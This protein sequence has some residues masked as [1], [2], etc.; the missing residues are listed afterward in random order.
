MH[1]GV[2]NSEE[3]GCQ[4][5]PE[6]SGEGAVVGVGEIC[7]CAEDCSTEIVPQIGPQP[8]HPWPDGGETEL[9][10]PLLSELLAGSLVGPDQLGASQESG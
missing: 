3:P 6:G 4:P 10:R 7:S 5:Q 9:S 8:L 2:S 1:L